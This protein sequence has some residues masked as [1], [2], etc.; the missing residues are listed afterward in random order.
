MSTSFGSVSKSSTVNDLTVYLSKIGT[1]Q[2]VFIKFAS[3]NMDEIQKVNFFVVRC[4]RRVLLDHKFFPCSSITFLEQLVAK[5][6]K[7]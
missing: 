1:T 7:K 5:P 6:S 2:V 4:D 3:L